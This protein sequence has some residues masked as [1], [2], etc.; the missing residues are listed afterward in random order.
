MNK[1]IVT[2]LAALSVATAFGGLRVRWDFEKTDDKGNVVNVAPEGARIT[3]L[4]RVSLRPGAGVDGSA[5]AFVEKGAVPQSGFA[6]LDYEA[7]TLDMRFA[8][9]GPVGS[10]HGVGLA[11]Y[12]WAPWKR[13]NFLLRITR[14]SRLE[15]RFTRQ[16]AKDGSACDGLLTE[17][18]HENVL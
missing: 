16:A 11:S 9:T 14:D 17:N 5:A 13:G 15:A 8:L 2:M 1:T 7:F 12:S 3:P 6:K 18:Q 10:K 4:G